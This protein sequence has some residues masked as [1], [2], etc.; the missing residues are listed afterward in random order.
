MIN[1]AVQN[2]AAACQDWIGSTGRMIPK[3]PHVGGLLDG[4][5]RTMPQQL[6]TFHCTLP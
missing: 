3:N 4:I 5:T 1:I 2:G 6:S